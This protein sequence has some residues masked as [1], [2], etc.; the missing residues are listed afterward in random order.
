MRVG[1][2]FI[3]LQG[4]PILLGPAIGWLRD[5]VGA[6]YPTTLGCGLLLP[7]LWL[8][9]TPDHK[10]FVW[11]KLEH[12]GQ[13]VVICA[14]FGVGFCILVDCNTMSFVPKYDSQQ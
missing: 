7:F 6:R 13:A 10:G 4:P 8:Q 9:A 11:A 5:R 12:H 3:G 14:L 1:M 2:I